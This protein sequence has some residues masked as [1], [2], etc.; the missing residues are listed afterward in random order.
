MVMTRK[1][2]RDSSLGSFVLRAENKL[3][4]TSG[5]HLHQAFDGVILRWEVWEAQAMCR[6]M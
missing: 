3:L 1:C 2:D 5:I 6:D 4:T